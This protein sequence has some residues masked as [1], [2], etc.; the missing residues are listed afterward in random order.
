MQ[1]NENLAGNVVAGLT[2]SAVVI[3]KAMA[4]A[5][6]AGLSVEAGM[7][8]ALIPMLVYALL[9]SSTKLSVSTTTTIA[10]LTGAQLTMAVPDGDPAKL[11]SAVG[12]LGVLVGIFL[13]L[14]GFLKMGFLANLISDP[15]LTGFKAGI[16]MVIIV[17][18]FPKILGLHI[19]KTGFLRD[20]FSIGNHVP[21]TSIPTQLSHMT[22]GSNT[23]I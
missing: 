3:P 14:A 5:G 16:A 6:I 4:Y 18:Q 13:L 8:A 15:V 9:G 10:I 12:A 21:E 23:R 19:T 7:Y 2:T 22:L 11:M 20:I 1:N 17:D